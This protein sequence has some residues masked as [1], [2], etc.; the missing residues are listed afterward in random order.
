MGYYLKLGSSKQIC[1]SKRV[2][3]SQLK[4]IKRQLNTGMSYLRTSSETEVP[5][6]SMERVSSFAAMLGPLFGM[7]SRVLALSFYKALTNEHHALKC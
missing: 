6:Y 2:T 7:E 3:R 1:L 4:Q 5:H